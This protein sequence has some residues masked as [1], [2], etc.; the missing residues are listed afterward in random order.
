MRDLS[1]LNRELSHVLLVTADPDA[2]YLQPDNAIKVQ[3]FAAKAVTT[4]LKR[5]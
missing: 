4:D 5:L 2:H 3:G 1:K